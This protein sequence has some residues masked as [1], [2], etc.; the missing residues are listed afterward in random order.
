MK[1]SLADFAGNQEQLLILEDQRLK[2]GRYSQTYRQFD[3]QLKMDG[4]VLS[5]VVL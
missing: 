2:M 4:E 1:R 5:L 3:S